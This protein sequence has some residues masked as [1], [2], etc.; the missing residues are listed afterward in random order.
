MSNIDEVQRSVQHYFNHLSGPNYVRLLDTPHVWGLQFGQ[1]IMPR[2]LERQADFE[3][4]IVE[5]V[6]KARYRCDLSS[7]NSPDPDWVRAILGAIDTALSTPMG[8]TESTQFRFLFGQTPLSPVTAPPNYI[9]F[10]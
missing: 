5:I 9:D 3:R 8:R 10:R 2:A 1:A 7:L 6:Q 4:A